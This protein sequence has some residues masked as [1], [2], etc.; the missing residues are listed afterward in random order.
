MLPLPAGTDFGIYTLLDTLG[1]GGFAFVY[2]AQDK[3]LGRRVCIK[4]HAP[5]DICRRDA[6]TGEIVPLPGLE[7]AFAGSLADFRQEAE[8]LA[9]LRHPQVPSIHEIFESGGTAYVVTDYAEGSALPQWL[10]EA[11]E[12]RRQLPFLLESAL[13]ILQSLHREGVLHRDIKPGNLML[14]DDGVLH[15]GDFGLA[16]VL[17]SGEQAP[18]VTQ[19]HDGTLRYMAPERLLRGENSF[20][21]D[22]YSLGLTLYELLTNRPAFQETE[23]G[24]LIHRICSEPIKPLQDEGELGAIINKSISYDPADRYRSMDDMYADLQRFL[25]GEPV[26]ARP[27]SF[28]RRYAMWIKRRPAVALWSHAAALLVVLLLVSV[29]VGYRNES[30]QREQAERNAEIA[31]AALQRIFSGVGGS[32]VSSEHGLTDKPTKS[33]ARLLEDLMPYYE[34]IASQ[35]ESGGEKMGDACRVMASIAYSTQDFATATEYFR[36]AADFFP[37][38]SVERMRAVNGLA[39]SMLRQKDKPQLRREAYKLLHTEANAIGDDDPFEL[40]LEKVR[41]LMT[42]AS[43]STQSSRGSRRNTGVERLA[44]AK[45]LHDLLQEQ[46]ANETLR[47]MQVELLQRSGAREISQLLLTGGQS[48]RQLIDGW[49]KEDPRNDAYRQAYVQA[50]LRPQ[51]FLPGRDA[52]TLEEWAKGVNYMRSILAD[53]PGDSDLLIRFINVSD[54]YAAAL[55]R[56]KKTDEARRV[57]EQALG[58]LSLLTSRDDFTPEQR[59]R[60]AMLVSMHPSQDADRSQQQQEIS[61]LLQSSDQKR[62][63]ELRRNLQR[64]R[65]NRQRMRRPYPPRR[66]SQD[67]PTNP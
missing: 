13:R 33:D 29:S 25:N 31:D 37:K 54:R 65:E 62:M 52:V 48:L 38:G 24:S 2:L 36:R 59:E 21:G 16:T 57:N 11:P 53:N 14:D 22:Q 47:L 46:P 50:L 30:V 4:E 5:Q 60:L 12:R 7:R 28:L 3:Q 6:E 66:K 1:H 56:Q 20:A 41:A 45:L 39:A 40:R 19:S 51:G 27:A 17:N 32:H 10:A 49:V 67:K 26:L 34:E 35:A 64:M 15:V 42:L 18:L 58:V 9:A 43:R 55:S 61:L 8:V 44:A 23:P 63:Q